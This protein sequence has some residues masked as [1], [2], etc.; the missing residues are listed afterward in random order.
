MNYIKPFFVRFR[1]K[2][3]D[4]RELKDTLLLGKLIDVVLPK[5][6]NAWNLKVMMISL[7]DLL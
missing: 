3:E 5:K 4:V 2:Q 7:V 6:T 1:E